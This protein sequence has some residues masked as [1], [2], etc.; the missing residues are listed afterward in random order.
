MQIN[1]GLQVTKQTPVNKGDFKQQVDRI[2]AI[3]HKIKCEHN[4]TVK[5]KIS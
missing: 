5:Y 2:N 3:L 4:T 1:I